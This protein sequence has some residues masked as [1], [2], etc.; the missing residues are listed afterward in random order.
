MKRKIMMD[1]VKRLN[2]SV[3]YFKEN[4]VV[5]LE[6]GRYE[7]CRYFICFHNTH[8]VLAAWRTQ[9]E[10]IDGLRVLIKE[11]WVYQGCLVF[12]VA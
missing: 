11:K 3:V 5:E 6:S 8:K 2:A 12:K 1:L 10:A 4:P 9:M 7:K